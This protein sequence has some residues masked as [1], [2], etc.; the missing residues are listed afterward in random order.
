MPDVSEVVFC[1]YG[2]LLKTRVFVILDPL[3][4]LLAILKLEKYH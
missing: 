2:G 4:K 3:T 1:L